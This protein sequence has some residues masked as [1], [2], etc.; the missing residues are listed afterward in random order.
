MKHPGEPTASVH[1]FS[2]LVQDTL[3]AFPCARGSV[4]S[5]RAPGVIDVMGGIGEDSGS[6]VLTSTLGLAVSAAMWFRDDDQVCIRR[7]TEGEGVRDFPLPAA[8]FDPSTT[9]PAQI[10][11]MCGEGDNRSVLPTC[12]TLRQALADGLVPGPLRGLM[13][14]LQSDFPPAADFGSTWVEAAAVVDGLCRLFDAKADSLRKSRLCAD[15][16]I[17]LTDQY[18]LRTPMTALCGPSDGSLLQLRFHP[19]VLCQTLELPQGVSVVAARTHLARPTTRQRMINTRMCAE[20][21][22]RMIADLQR[23]DGVRNPSAAGSLATITP[24]EYVERYRDRLPSKITGK[25]FIAKFGSFRGLNGELDPEATYKVRS[26][27]EHHIYENRRVHE[28]TACLVRARRNASVDSLMRAGE[29]MYASH[30]SHSQRCGIGGVEADQLVSAVRSLGPR[31]GL[32]GAK[33]TAGGAG[34]EVAV[35]LR[36]DD[37]ARAALAQ[38]ISTAQASSGQPIQTFG[39]PLGGAEL[40]DPSE[41]D[42]AVSHTAAP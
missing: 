41:L 6:L 18:N 38:A 5:V 4:V 28:F 12:L 26:R 2:A 35:L 17:A 20:M 33:V 1:H 21:G 22:H 10:E 42:P 37:Q 3:A 27:A 9:G 7:A 34:G 23:A 14:L 13:V 16:V 32:F 40:C 24:A 11:T 8:A 30:W 29:L 39:G 31:T 15:A 25:A 36:D 19:Q